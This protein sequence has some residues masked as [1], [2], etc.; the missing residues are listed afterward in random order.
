MRV[1]KSRFRPWLDDPGP[2]QPWADDDK[3]L[4]AIAEILDTSSDTAKES[5]REN[6]GTNA[7]LF[8]GIDYIDRLAQLPV[9]AESLFRTAIAIAALDYHLAHAK[10]PRAVPGGNTNPSN[11]KRWDELGPYLFERVRELTAEQSAG[12]LLS[13]AVFAATVDDAHPAA[14]IERRVRQQFDESGMFES[15]DV[16]VDRSAPVVGGAAWLRAE[17]QTALEAARKALARKT[18]ALIEVDG[19]PQ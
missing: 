13:R 15:V 5:L 10:P 14:E 6:Y 4:K 1:Y 12:S 3:D 16:D 11:R 19:R 7:T 2:W 8:G 17:T 9:Q 18:P